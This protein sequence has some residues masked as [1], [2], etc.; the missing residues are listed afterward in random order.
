MNILLPAGLGLDPHALKRMSWLVL[1]LCVVPPATEVAV[2]T[3]I[4]KF[5]LDIPW[6]WGILLGLLLAAVSPAV[7]I[8]CLFELQVNFQFLFDFSIKNI[9][10]KGS[11]LWG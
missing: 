11:R 3:V 8:P 1:L 10:L 7:V 4:S 9:F 2:V 6:L 5:L